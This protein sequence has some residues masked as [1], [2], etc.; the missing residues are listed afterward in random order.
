[1]TKLL[2]LTADEVYDRLLNVDKIK[3]VEGQIRFYLGNV[4]IIVRQKDVVGNIIQ[5][6]LEGW[7]RKNHIAFAPNINTQMP[8]DIF[9][10]PDNHTKDLLEVKAFNYSASP[11]FDIADFKAYSREI[12]ERPYMLHTSILFSVT[13]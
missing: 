6:W 9:L 5:E 2:K 13:A 8:P 12:I 4:S 7:L 3:T 11:G 1:M 10:D